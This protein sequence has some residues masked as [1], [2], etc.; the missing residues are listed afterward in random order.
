[1]GVAELIAEAQAAPLAVLGALVVLVVL[2]YVFGVVGDLHS[3]AP[4]HA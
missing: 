3:G 1:M 2:S 4:L